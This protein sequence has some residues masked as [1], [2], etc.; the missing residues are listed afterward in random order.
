VTIDPKM[1]ERRRVWST[2]ANNHMQI[3]LNANKPLA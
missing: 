1:K 2:I 3:V